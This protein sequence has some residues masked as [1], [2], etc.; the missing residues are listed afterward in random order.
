MSTPE[1]LELADPTGRVLRLLSLLQ[2]HRRWSSDEL[3]DELRVTARTVRRDI[4]RLR[5]L[6]YDVDAL[7]GPEGGYR[8]AAGSHLPPLMIDNDEAV[9]I[10]V[11][12]WSATA[13]PLEGIEETALRALAKIE[14]LLPDHVRRRTQAITTNMSAHR[15][16]GEKVAINMESIAVLTDTCRDSE[17][18]RFDYVDKE[19]AATR[20]LVEPH[21]LVAMDE[22]WYLLAWDVRRDDW[23]T[24]RLDRLKEPRR[25]G[26]RFERRPIPQDD[27]A[28]FVAENLG[29]V[30]QPFEVE[31]TLGVDR[32]AL[33]AE[34]PWLEERITTTTTSTTD[35]VVQGR[36]TTQLAAQASRL[37]M[38]FDLVVV[39]TTPTADQV[40][41]QLV[42]LSQRLA[43][44]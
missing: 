42:E 25:A 8:L 26:A 28:A 35:V 29:R 38:R 27:P 34:M 16:Y 44:A 11:G 22:R 21:H 39:G 12:L 5:T 19:G 31:L 41:R 10:A 7:S 33:V 37:A 9:A 20:R 40:R 4:D 15:W 24:F 36:T 3:A 32:D 14:A 30:P 6:G 18:L 43:L 2:T 1:E 23:R 17:Q 13:T